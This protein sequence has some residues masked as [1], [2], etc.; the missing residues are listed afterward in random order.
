MAKTNEIIF[1]LSSINN[2]TKLFKA[3]YNPIP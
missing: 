2:P 1:P 3:L